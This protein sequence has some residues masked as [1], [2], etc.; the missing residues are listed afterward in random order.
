MHRRA[1]VF[2]V[3]VTIRVYTCTHL[4]G[5]SYSQGDMDGYTRVSM[6][7]CVFVCVPPH[8]FRDMCDT[9]WGLKASVRHTPTIPQRITRRLRCQ[10]SL[11]RVSCPASRSETEDIRTLHSPHTLSVVFTLFLGISFSPFLC[12][13]KYAVMHSRQKTK[14]K[15]GSAHGQTWFSH[16]SVLKLLTPVCG[17]GLS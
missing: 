9:T 2:A 3:S 4:Y 7:T 6:C 14:V 1:S 16:F 8:D 12:Q 11:P 5:Q 17:C 13:W 10:D 15:E